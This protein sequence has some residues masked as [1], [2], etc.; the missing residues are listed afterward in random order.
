MN[1]EYEPQGDPSHLVEPVVFVIDDDAEMRHALERLF[2]N[3]G[4]KVEAFADA[5]EF[6]SKLMPA[7]DGC[8]VLDVKM[9]GM[10]GPELQAALIERNVDLPIIFL[11]GYSSIPQAVDAMRAG[12]VDFLEKPF[13]NQML[14]ERV[15]HA[16]R[17]GTQSR[18]H[19]LRLAEFARKVAALTPRERE[20]MHRVAAGSLSKTIAHDLS[21][22]VR[23]VDIHRAR[24]MQ[25]LGTQ[26]VAELARMC[27]LIGRSSG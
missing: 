19:R 2:H 12:A 1:F 24:L 6:L 3:A 4:Y 23:T 20:V 22:S 9:P 10:T 11:T 15:G 5:R 27:T 26:S 25:K 17:L 18:E 8:L 21:I 16:L 14:I 13:D 7:C